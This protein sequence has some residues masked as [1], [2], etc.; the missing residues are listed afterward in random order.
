MH[1]LLSNNRKVVDSFWSNKLDRK[2]NVTRK[3]SVNNV[4]SVNTIIANIETKCRFAKSRIDEVSLLDGNGDLTGDFIDVDNST[5]DIK[6]WFSK[7]LA[8]TNERIKKVIEKKEDEWL[9][10]LYKEKK[11]IADE[12]A[13]SYT[14]NS[15]WSNWDLKKWD[16]L[17]DDKNTFWKGVVKPVDFVKTVSEKVISDV[18][19]GYIENKSKEIINVFTSNNKFDS[20][21]NII[22]VF[23]KTVKDLCE[24]ILSKINK[25]D[26]VNDLTWN[27]K[28]TGIKNIYSNVIDK[29][30]FW[31]VKDH[32]GALT[33]RAN[34][35]MTY[36][37][38]VNWYKS[39]T[40][41]VANKEDTAKIIKWKRFL[42]LNL[43]DIMSHLD[44]YEGV[45]ERT[46]FT[47]VNKM[48]D[49]A[50]INA[51]VAA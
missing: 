14:N 10:F 9:N 6:L 45:T 51:K 23:N 38:I 32:R 28:I 30:V 11:V 27:R 44:M 20:V 34:A 2:N 3:K 5:V 42:R 37:W 4:N 26:D 33:S 29:L 12:Y 40:S 39:V 36:K 21:K 17:L 16:G 19:F 41:W 24:N 46:V 35:S 48:Y 49:N 43:A 31:W 1:D 25:N 47:T 18:S 7:E 8:M 22:G 50:I 15:W 13:F